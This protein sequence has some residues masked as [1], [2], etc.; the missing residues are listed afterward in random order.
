MWDNQPNVKPASWVG[1]VIRKPEPVKVT[2][3]NNFAAP[4]KQGGSIVTTSDVL[5]ASE[6]YKKV[7]GICERLLESG[8][9]AMGEGYCISVSDIIFNM[10][11]QNGIKCHLVEV[12]LSAVDAKGSTYMVGFQTGG[13]DGKP[14]VTKV[15]THVVVVTDTE[16]PMI[17]DMSI[18][19]RL[20]DNY[21]CIID[22]AFNQGD[23]VICNIEFQKWHYI[24]QEKKDG[25]NLPQLHQ[26]SIL[27]RIATDK[28]VFNEMKS[29]K[30]LNMIGIG[31]SAFAV[32]NV[33]AK[34]WLDWYN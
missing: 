25:V 31:L 9:G 26:M 3:N 27:D 17:I 20:P 28:K 12:T 18:A 32:I 23:K 16:I 29:L 19:H 7:R 21:Q 34:V 8:L 33:I 10:L 24:Y 13:L 6:D 5:Y 2:Y 22:K 15:S 1:N 11:Q 14:D 4:A 30:L